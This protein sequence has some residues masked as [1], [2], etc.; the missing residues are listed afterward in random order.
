MNDELETNADELFD[1]L[2]RMKKLRKLDV[3]ML[4]PKDI[5][6][7]VE[8]PILKGIEELSLYA[9]DGIAARGASALARC[10]YLSKLRSL[11]IRNSKVTAAH[12]R[13]ILRSKHFSHVEELDLNFNRFGPAGAKLLAAWP[14]T[15]R[16]RR[17]ELNRCKIP[18]KAMRSLLRSDRLESLDLGDNPIGDEGAI[19]IAAL[20][21]PLTSLNL[22]RVSLGD[23]G[24][25]ALAASSHR[26]AFLSV[27]ANHLGS[28]ARQALERRF[29]KA[30]HV[31]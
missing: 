14:N 25:M 22:H 30:L 31:F 10:A 23:S 7:L 9:D 2:E 21:A 15:A 27:G 3:G 18:W 16:L 26:L 19:V 12:L 28:D 1:A 29:G 24:A 6:R 17:L 13:T 8:L 11:N 4:K 20:R 5:E